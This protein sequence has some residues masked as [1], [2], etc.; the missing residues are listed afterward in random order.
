VLDP[1]IAAVT[2]TGSS[3]AGASVGASAGKA[4]KK[5][6]LEL[7][8]SDYF[9]VLA[10]ADLDAAAKVGVR[11]RYQNTGQSCIAAKRFI[12]EESVYDRYVAAFVEQTRALKIGDPT[13]RE[14][15]IGPLAR[16][17]LRET[18][19]AQVRDTVAAGAKL[20]LGGNVLDR[21]GAYY[22][23]TVVSEVVPGM[24][25][26][27]EETFGPAAAMM[28]ARDVA[29]AVELAN[30]TPFGLGGNLWTSDISR[31]ERLAADLQSGNVFINGMTA[32]D[33]RLPFGGVK[34]SGHGR[35]LSEFGIREFVNIQTVWIGPDSGS[36]GEPAT[37]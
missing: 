5:T 16:F 36:S 17:D 12:I 18:L 37:E 34:N 11:A 27:S 20:L 3:E 9:I 30:D 19:A 29:H 7:G 13:D 1:R 32:S 22:A 33:P 35:E 28:R 4:I 2:L 10:D 23:P 24:R 25:M 15:Q 8:G 26:A 31:A 6:V 21:P 14:T